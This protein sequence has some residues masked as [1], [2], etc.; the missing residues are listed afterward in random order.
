MLYERRVEPLST[1]WCS[2]RWAGGSF[3]TARRAYT[4]RVEGII[5]TPE[6]LIL[7]TM[8]GGAEYQEVEASCGH[9]FVGSDHAG[10]VSFVPAHCRR[11]LKLKAVASEWA[12]VSID[13]AVLEEDA[14]SAT[15]LL[16]Q[17]T[18][19]NVSDE[20]LR[21]GVLELARLNRLDGGLDPL[22]CEVMSRSLANYLLRRHVHR[23]I[24]EKCTCAL[25]RWKLRR[26]SDYI[27][28]NL[29]SELRISNLAR[30]ADLTPSYFHRAF[31]AA[32]GR[33]PLAFI[34]QQRVR[35]AMEL[36]ARQDVSVSEA[37]VRVGFVSPA[38][39]TRVFRQATGVNPSQYR[40]TGLGSSQMTE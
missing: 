16:D 38:H 3:D 22:Y 8:K 40:A 17:A 2:L 34:N 18:F 13:P 5:C 36:L 25:P 37:C 1:E 19:T 10:T 24:V 30:M 12:S 7:V 11:H 28:A 31:R 15:G 29:N 27:E 21:A 33:T 4:D 14:P 32:T 39:F 26:V 9:H 6:H 35:R 20:F 23:R